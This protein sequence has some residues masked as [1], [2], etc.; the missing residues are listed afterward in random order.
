MFVVFL[1][2]ERKR[3]KLFDSVMFRSYLNS[4]FFIFLWQEAFDVTV[5]FS[6]IIFPEREIRAICIGK[7]DNPILSDI[8]RVDRN[9]ADRNFFF[10][11]SG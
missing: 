9:F 5:Y 2:S 10:G 1:C 8:D 6:H 11:K 3:D 4:M 7:K